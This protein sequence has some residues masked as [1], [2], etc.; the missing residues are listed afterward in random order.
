MRVIEAQTC[1]ALEQ[2]HALLTTLCAAEAARQALLAAG[3][4]AAE[5]WA[6]PVLAALELLPP[7]LQPLLQALLHG[8]EEHICVGPLVP[9]PSAELAHPDALVALT[10]LGEGGRIFEI[11]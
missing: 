11:T 6:R 5:S 7:A 10:T 4:P 3:A 2:A 1:T 9:P 8:L